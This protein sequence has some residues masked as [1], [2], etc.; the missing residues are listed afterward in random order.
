M[1]RDEQFI[2]ENADADDDLDVLLATHR[3]SDCAEPAFLL[4]DDEGESLWLCAECA[5]ESEREGASVVA[6]ARAA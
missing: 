3:C 5:G 6:A 2:F 4:F 1:T